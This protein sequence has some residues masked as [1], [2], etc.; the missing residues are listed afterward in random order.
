M[1]NNHRLITLDIKDLYVNIPIKDI[2]FM[3][4]DRLSFRNTEINIKKQSIQLLREILNRN[5]FQFDKQYYKPHQ[6]I[7]MG[8]PISGLVYLQHFED[9]MMKHWI[10]TGK[11]MHYNRYVD[12]IMFDCEEPMKTRFALI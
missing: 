10:E 7:A 1:K 11:I 12:D 6:G 5:Y 8:S 3:K 2:L 4:E 9:I